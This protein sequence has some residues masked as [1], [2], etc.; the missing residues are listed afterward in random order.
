VIRIGISA[1]K[2]SYVSNRKGNKDLV[3]LNFDVTKKYE[4]KYEG[5]YNVIKKFKCIERFANRCKNP[6]EVITLIVDA[7]KQNKNYLSMKIK[8]CPVY[9]DALDSKFVYESLMN[10]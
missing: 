8:T 1:T 9:N 7:Y 10:N 6:L 5:D 4:P 2:F 3:M